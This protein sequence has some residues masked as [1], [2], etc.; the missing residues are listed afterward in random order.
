M[1]NFP[2]LYELSPLYLLQAALTVWMLIDAHR[3]QVDY[4]WFWIILVLQ[5]FG[6]WA[7][8]ALYKVKEIRGGSGWVGGLF[9]RPPA[10]EELRHRIERSPTVANRLE[11]GA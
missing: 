5:P 7:Y 2:I 3:R 4:Y 11:F 9:H 10:L 6:P 8:F 1:F